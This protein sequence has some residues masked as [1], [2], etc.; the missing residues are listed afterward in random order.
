[1]PD[2]VKK[3]LIIDDD[4]MV[5]DSLVRTL[6]LYG[7]EVWA[8]RSGHV[9]EGYAADIVICDWDL[10]IY[11]SR[12]GGEI[13]TDLLMVL[14]DARFI[15]VSGLPRDVPE[16]VEFFSKGDVIELLHALESD[17]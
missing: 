5:V 11:D 15:I 1:M 16:G 12:N 6:Q 10:G 8:V 7:H 3:I 2:E 14:P 9:P 13:V 4:E 17:G